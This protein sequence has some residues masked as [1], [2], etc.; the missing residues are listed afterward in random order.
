[1]VAFQPGEVGIRRSMGFHPAKM[2]RTR[3]FEE[4]SPE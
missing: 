3:N 4:L 1:M 2:A